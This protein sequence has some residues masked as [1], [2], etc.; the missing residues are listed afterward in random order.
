MAVIAAHSAA[1]L[2]ALFLGATIFSARKGT[3]L[4]RRMG[5]AYVGLMAVVAATGA[6]IQ[7]INPG[8]YSPIHLLIPVT[9]LGLWASLWGVRRYRQ[10][11]RPR[12]LRLHITTMISTFFFAL[13]LAGAFTLFP[14]R[15]FHQLLFG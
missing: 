12:Y 6:F 14:G 1:A 11:R 13:V 15:L 4:H 9:I 3:P 2:L 5:W 7:E 10:T 8:H